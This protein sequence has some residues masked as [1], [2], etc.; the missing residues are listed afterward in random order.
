MPGISELQVKETDRIAVMAR[1][2]KACG[3][4]VNEQPDSLIVIGQRQ[5]L[6]ALPVI[7]SMITALQ[8]PFLSW[9]W[10]ASKQSQ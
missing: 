10:L 1:G 9:E 3:V 4:S 6:A 2:L 8:C 7:L 5:L